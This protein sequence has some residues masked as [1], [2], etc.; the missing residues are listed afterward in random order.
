MASTCQVCAV[1]ILP[2]IWNTVRANIRY[3]ACLGEAAFWINLKYKFNCSVL[4]KALL[5]YLVFTQFRV[6][7]GS[8]LKLIRLLLWCSSCLVSS[9][10]TSVSSY[11][12]FFWIC[13]YYFVYPFFYHKESPVHVLNPGYIKKSQHLTVDRSIQVWYFK[14]M[15]NLYS[16]NRRKRNA[17]VSVHF[18]SYMPF[19]TLIVNVQWAGKQ[20]LAWTTLM[21]PS[22]WYLLMKFKLVKLTIAAYCLSSFFLLP[23]PSPLPMPFVVLRTCGRVKIRPCYNEEPGAQIQSADWTRQ[24]SGLLDWNYSREAT[25]MRILC[26]STFLSQFS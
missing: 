18:S 21:L 23:H 14:H 7:L 8:E 16:D 15:S 17:F 3:I 6:E 12:F 22:V 10:H 19:P 4:L 24:L 2:K 9:F 11:V 13:E 5:E 20:T 26:F 25:Q 1:I